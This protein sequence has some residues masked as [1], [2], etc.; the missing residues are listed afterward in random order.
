[1][2]KMLWLAALLAFS[3]P[4]FADDCDDKECH[5]KRGFDG[6][7]A[8]MQQDP[9]FVAKMQAKKAEMKARKEAF[10][11]NTGTYGRF[12]EAVKTI[13]PRQE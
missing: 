8:V 11:K 10:E 9:E 5:K 7:A 6:R 1:M 12:S 13:D 2:K 4:A 3:V